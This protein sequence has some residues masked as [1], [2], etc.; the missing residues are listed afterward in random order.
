M[1]KI[2]KINNCVV[3]G[4]LFHVMQYRQ[5]YI[6]YLYIL[7]SAEYA[8]LLRGKFEISVL[9]D[10]LCEPGRGF[11][12]SLGGQQTTGINPINEHSCGLIFL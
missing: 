2:I 11:D 9:V 12:P 5:Y 6:Y 8:A 4:N 7:S 1:N 10:I 3:L